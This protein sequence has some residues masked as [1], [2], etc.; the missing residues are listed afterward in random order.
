MLAIILPPLDL[1][2]EQCSSDFSAIEGDEDL[3]V[4][5]MLS[6]YNEQSAP[7]LAREP[8]SLEVLLKAMGTRSQPYPTLPSVQVMALEKVGGLVVFRSS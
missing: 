3:L 2:L 1:L 7:L 4:Q 8:R 5:L 6:K